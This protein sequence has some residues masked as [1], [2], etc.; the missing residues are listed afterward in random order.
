MYGESSPILAKDLANLRYNK[1][2]VVFVYV[3]ANGNALVWQTF[4]GVPS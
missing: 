3:S 1:I 2:L 4:N